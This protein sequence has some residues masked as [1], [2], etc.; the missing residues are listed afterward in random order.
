VNTFD[1]G[2]QFNQLDDMHDHTT[3]K[4]DERKKNLKIA[5]YDNASSNSESWEEATKTHTQKR[6]HQQIDSNDSDEEGS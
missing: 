4:I 3:Q 5:N 6:K 1:E 2:N